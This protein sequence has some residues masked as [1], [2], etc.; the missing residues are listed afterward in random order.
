MAAGTYSSPTDHLVLRIDP[1]PAASITGGF[2]T[3][4]LVYDVTSYW[5]LTGTQVHSFSPPLELVLANT[6]GDSNAVPATFENGS[7]RPIAVVPASA[8]LPS[9]RADGYFVGP[10]GIHILTTHLSEFTLLHDRFPPPPPAGF[11]G[12]V[13]ADGLTLRWVPGDDETGAV[14]QVQLYVDGAH[15]TS[16]DTTQFETKLGPIAAGDPRTFTMT[17]TDRAGTSAPTPTACARYHRSP[18]SR[19]TTRSKP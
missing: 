6:T 11:V 10:D 14:A 5:S 9:G 17:E 7:W 16:F 18:D 4:A 2:A 8:I 3:G 19:S 15:T 1:N 13:A 12:V